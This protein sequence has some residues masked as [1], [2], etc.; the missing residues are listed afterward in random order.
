MIRSGKN[1]FCDYLAIYQSDFDDL[2][3][4]V[5]RTMSSIQQKKIAE[6]GSL[7]REIIFFRFGSGRVESRFSADPI[8]IR[9]ENSEHYQEP[10]SGEN[11]FGCAMPNEAQK[12]PK[13]A[14][15]GSLTMRISPKPAR[16]RVLYPEHPRRYF[17]FVDEKLFDGLQLSVFLPHFLNN[18]SSTG[19]LFPTRTY[20]LLV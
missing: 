5:T 12:T 20:F 4:V 14:P 16:E 2:F 6:I 19:R 18:N 7:D 10:T 15:R 9:S 11:N 1:V 17:S 3:F 13:I 8:R